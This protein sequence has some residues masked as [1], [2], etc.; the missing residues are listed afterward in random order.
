MQT[1]TFDGEE[2][3]IANIAYIGAIQPKY[4][5]KK[6]YYK[7]FKWNICLGGEERF[8]KNYYFTVVTN[9]GMH[10]DCNNV[11]EADLI[12]Q[13]QNLIDTIHKENV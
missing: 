9:D 11:D 1:I 6:V 13:R 4:S 2:F 3:V 7:F 8:L 10:S 5:W 12:E